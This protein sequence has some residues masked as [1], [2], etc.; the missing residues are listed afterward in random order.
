M[1]QNRY[2]KLLVLNIPRLWK[3]FTVDLEVKGNERMG[4]CWIENRTII[5]SDDRDTWDSDVPEI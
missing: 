4:L 2:K 1:I 3:T 5:I